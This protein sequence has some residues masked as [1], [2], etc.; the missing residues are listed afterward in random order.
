MTSVVLTVVGSAV[1][2]AAATF[3]DFRLGLATLGLILLIIGLFVQ[4]EGES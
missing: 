4:I 3:V 2:V 1:L